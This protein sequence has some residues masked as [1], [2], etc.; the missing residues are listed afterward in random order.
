MKR[1]AMIQRAAYVLASAAIV[2]AAIVAWRPSC[3]VGYVQ[4]N[5]VPVTTASQAPLYLDKVRLAPV[6]NGTALLRQS[7]GTLTL[8]GEVFGNNLVPLCQIEVKKDRITTVTVSLLERP[9]RC[10]CRL[11]AGGDT[12]NRLCVS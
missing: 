11:N 10:V 3:D 8:R 4:L 2:G 12:A 7:V 9:P 6:R 1:G 5:T